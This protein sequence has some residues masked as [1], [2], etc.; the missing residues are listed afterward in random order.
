MKQSQKVVQ[1]SV[2]L[3]LVSSCLC[4]DNAWLSRWH[5]RG[6]AILG[7]SHFQCTRRVCKLCW[8]YVIIS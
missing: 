2:L 4:S 3:L 6:D 8:W 7:C 1:T 5:W